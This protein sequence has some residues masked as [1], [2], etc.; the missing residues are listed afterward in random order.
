ML[1]QHHTERLAEVCKS[2]L[3]ESHSHT[4]EEQFSMRTTLSRAE[5]SFAM[6]PVLVSHE[7]AAPQTLKQGQG[8]TIQTEHR[9][10][11]EHRHPGK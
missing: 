7:G 6:G 3:Q 8:M 4:A 10:T 5:Q 1:P 9:P 2:Q 11:D